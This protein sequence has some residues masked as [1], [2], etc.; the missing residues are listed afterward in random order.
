MAKEIMVCNQHETPLIWTFTFPYS[1]YFCMYGNHSGGMLGTGHKVELTP[2][3]KKLKTLY[4][5]RWGQLKKYIVVGR[6]FRGD[7]PKCAN[8]KEEHN[9]HLTDDE[10]RRSVMALAK[11]EEYADGR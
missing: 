6:F 4:N 11:L 9:Y 7:C 1:E 2:K 10:K 3:L 8:F 5:R